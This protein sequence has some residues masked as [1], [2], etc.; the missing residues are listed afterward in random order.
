MLTDQVFIIA[1]R[2]LRLYW[3]RVRVAAGA[4]PLLDLASEA[5]VVSFLTG[6][7]IVV[8]GEMGRLRFFDR[9]T[10]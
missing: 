6:V 8:I 5:C 7:S 10:G 1:L 2:F 9:L 4:F 3:D